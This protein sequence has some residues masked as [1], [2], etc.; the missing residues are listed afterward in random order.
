LV[1]FFLVDFLFEFSFELFLALFDVLFHFIFEVTLGHDVNLKGFF[2]GLL[3]HH[4][5]QFEGIAIK[6][7]RN[8]FMFLIIEFNTDL[9]INTKTELDELFSPIFK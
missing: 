3:A 1:N 9:T 8:H 4:S 7:I 6:T 5:L 2:V